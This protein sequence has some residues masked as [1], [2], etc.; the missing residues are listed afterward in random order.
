MSTELPELITVM[1]VDDHQYI[2]DGLKSIIEKEADIKVVGEANNGKQA[3][4]T[5]NALSPRPSVIVTDFSMPEMDGLSLVKEV[6]STFP[7]IK[8]LVLSMHETPE[9]LQQIIDA[10]AEGYILKSSNT[11]ELGLAIRTVCNGGT[12]YSQ[13]LMPLLLK[14]RNQ[15]NSDQL[16][17]SLSSRELEVLE[18]MLLEKSSKEIADELFISKRT[19]DTHRINVMEKTNQKTLIGLY[20]YALQH[21]FD[22]ERFG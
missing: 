13:K 5:L 22:G 18:L 7:E 21:G 6:K 17:Q 12:F 15:N 14:T 19:V 10:E 8:M 1:L 16:K 9:H 20:K 3:L 11:I 2:I 4:R